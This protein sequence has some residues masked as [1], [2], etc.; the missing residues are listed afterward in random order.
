MRSERERLDIIREIGSRNQGSFLVLGMDTD[1]K[2]IRVNDTI[3][4][5]TGK[6]R[7]EFID[8]PFSMFLTKHSSLSDKWMDFFLLAKDDK[9]MGS[10]E[11]PM[12]TTKG[13]DVMVSWMSFPIKNDI[14]KIS[15][16]NLVGTPVSTQDLCKSQPYTKTDIDTSQKITEEKKK[17]SSPKKSKKIKILIKSKQSK[18]GTEHPKVP[19]EQNIKKSESSK[20]EQKQPKKKKIRIKIKKPKES[21]KKKS[22]NDVFK[23]RKKPLGELSFKE[24]RTEQ[25]ERKKETEGGSRQLLKKFIQ[26]KPINN[27]SEKELLKQLHTEVTHLKKKQGELEQINKDLERKIQAAQIKRNDIRSFFNERLRFFRDAVGITEKRKEF[28]NMLYQIDQAKDK[29]TQLETDMILEKKE[30]KRKIEEFFTWREKLEQLETEIEKRRKYLAEHE[31]FLNKQ[32]DKAIK[33]QLE[34]SAKEIDV[35]KTEQQKEDP[36]LEKGLLEQDNLIDSV[37]VGT[38]ILQRGRIRQAND[39]LVKIL[40]YKE[41]EIVGKHLVDFVGPTG[42]PGIEQHYLNRLKGEDTSSYNTSF[43]T[44]DEEEISVYVTVKTGNFQGERAE[45]ATF[46]EI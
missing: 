41:K 11:L 13:E 19:K 9:L 32:F 45:I 15:S 8:I 24:T 23:K 16:L 26:K 29:L 21:I 39:A 22:L 33:L 43:L 36:S 4:Q 44:K 6:K 27:L 42:L 31:D 34:L 28:K 35:N 14:G 18:K 3:E 40:G 30:F 2:I 1:G 5:I 38:A 12:Q 25:K 37:E 10:V 46:K 20:K 7:D 17:P